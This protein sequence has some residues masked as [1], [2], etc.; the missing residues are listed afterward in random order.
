VRD[1]RSDVA[2]CSVGS[3][4]Q[5]RVRNAANAIA[6]GSNTAAIALLTTVLQKVDGEGPDWMIDSPEREALAACIV[7][8]IALLM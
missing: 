7:E 3:V 1:P 4:D 5:R 6:Q 2:E 8:L